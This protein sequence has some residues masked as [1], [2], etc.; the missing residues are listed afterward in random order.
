LGGENK[1]MKVKWFCSVGRR[2]VQII[3]MAMWW[4]GHKISVKYDSNFHPPIKNPC[5]LLA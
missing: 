3:E 1:L 2:A 5:C 4:K